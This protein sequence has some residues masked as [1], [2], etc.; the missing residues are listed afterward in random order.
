[1]S[2]G[3]TLDSLAVL[4]Q[5]RRNT[6]NRKTARAK[7]HFSLDESLNQAAEP[8]V[9]FSVPL[10]A[11]ALRAC[12]SLWQFYSLTTIHTHTH[13][14][15]TQHCRLQR[16]LLGNLLREDSCLQTVISQRHHLPSRAL[17]TSH[18][19]QPLLTKNLLSF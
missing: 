2:V 16:V 18:K 11:A 10:P 4:L 19:E 9:R 3:T 8:F 12:P 15:N 5:A 17:Y 13:T 14:S 1:M 7:R 6:V